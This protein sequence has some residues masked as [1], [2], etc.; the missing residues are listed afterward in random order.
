MAIRKVER[1]SFSELVT[2]RTA[3]RVG[4]ADPATPYGLSAR[5]PL[6]FSLHRAGDNA[7]RSE[8]PGRSHRDV[9]QSRDSPYTQQ[10]PHLIQ[11]EG[12]GPL[13]HPERSDRKRGPL[14]HPERSDRKRGSLCHPERS[15]PKASG[16]EGS[17]AR[18]MPG[19]RC[20]TAFEGSFKHDEASFGLICLPN[21]RRDVSL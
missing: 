16:V 10:T 19:G 5:R 14:C 1:P 9:P 6:V 11:S 18:R 7:V 2:M 3:K 8:S 12:I 21:C 13:L 15:E 17:R 20:R 4:S